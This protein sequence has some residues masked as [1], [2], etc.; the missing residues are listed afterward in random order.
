MAISPP[1][2]PK[3]KSHRDAFIVGTIGCI[4]VLV[5]AGVYAANHNGAAPNLSGTTTPGAPATTAPTTASQIAASLNV[6]SNGV[7]ALGDT[8]D[9]D[10]SVAVTFVV[11]NTAPKAISAYQTATTL[12]VT[13]SL[14][15]TYSQRLLT[16]CTDP[17]APGESR[18]GP[19][20]LSPTTI[21][22]GRQNCTVESWSMNRFD[23]TQIGLWNGL[24][25]ES[26]SYSLEITRITFAD[27]T[28][29]GSAETG[30]PSL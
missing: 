17:L 15:R 1:L 18:V 27:G 10:N 30:Q 9:S 24:Q 16:D 7:L 11:H 21:S 2:S 3:K 4:L 29:L 25:G 19:T 13:D 5:F 28:S 8:A 20:Q 22:I 23:P 14:G 6:T 12:S 26:G